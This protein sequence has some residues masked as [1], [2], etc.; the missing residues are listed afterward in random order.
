[1]NTGRHLA[2]VAC[3]LL[4]SA[5]P[6]AT[7]AE[8]SGAAGADGGMPAATRPWRAAEYARAAELLRAGHVPLPRLSDPSG[9]AI[10]ERMTSTE[11]LAYYREAAVPLR[12]RLPDLLDLIES[13]S[14][15]QR[16]YHADCEKNC[17]GKDPSSRGELARLR[18][19]TL[20]AWAALME[21]EEGM[22]G[23]PAGISDPADLSAMFFAVEVC[24][25]TGIHTAADRLRLLEAMAA[26]LPRLETGFTASE[27]LELQGRLERRAHGALPEEVRAL[28]RMLAEVRNT[29]T[30]AWSSAAHNPLLDAG[31]PAPGRAWRAADY[32]RVAEVLKSGRVPLPRLSDPLGRAAF[33]RLTSAENLSIHHDRSLPLSIRL[34]DLLQSFQSSGDVAQLYLAK[35]QELSPAPKEVGRLLAFVLHLSA[36]I[37][38]LVKEA[39]SGA[40]CDCEGS[41]DGARMTVVKM[42]VQTNGALAKP[43]FLT[44]QDRS[45]L[46]ATLATTIPRLKRVLSETG[47]T[48]YGQE[49]QALRSIFEK[50]EDL[51][52]IDGILAELAKR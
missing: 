37:A 1:M 4:A 28:D 13:M 19:F 33:D 12:S 38:D 35:P 7:T 3:L 30:P 47:R 22:P 52:A 25:N 10:V 31:V 42:L 9:R 43:G 50:A 51:R 34:A 41:L 21:L 40:P 17:V 11:N 44:P 14:A 23:E 24:L 20:H 45:A 6:G 49:V 15:V 8:P 46:L 36:A 32:H 39:S 16:L 5:A 2:C 26:T 27:L 48:E 18:A 29:L